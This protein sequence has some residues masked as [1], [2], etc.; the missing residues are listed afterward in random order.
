MI[1][2]LRA[3]FLRLISMDLFYVMAAFTARLQ[4][5]PTQKNQPVTVIAVNGLRL[6]VKSIET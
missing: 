1:G 6:T 4:T 5:H 2:K 3:H